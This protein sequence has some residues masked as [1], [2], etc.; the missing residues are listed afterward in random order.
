MQHSQTTSQ[1]GQS[2]M[3]L[4]I[5]L[6]ILLLMLVGMAEITFIFNDYLQMLDGVRYGARDSS[7]N[8]PYT[9][10]FPKNADG[11]L[12][13]GIPSVYDQLTHSDDPKY[14]G[15]TVWDCDN[16]LNFFA[17]AAC[18]TDRN[19][20]Y[21]TLVKDGS[22]R[23][24][25]ANPKNPVP[26]DDIVISLFATQWITDT[27]APV[28]KRYAGNV[29]RG[30]YLVNGQNTY[31]G[32]L[33]DDNPTTNDEDVNESGWSYLGQMCSVI[34][35]AQVASKLINAA[36]STGMVLVEVFRAR[37][38]VLNAPG[39][40]VIPDPLL[41]HAYAIFPLV[42]IEPTKTPTP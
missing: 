14:P 27:T 13:T 25:G 11:T 3:E 2:F 5:F 20:S 9:Q 33:S 18:N 16:T 31:F 30:P 41:I 15:Y 32:F 4:A 36:P 42:S 24:C 40:E 37:H 22:T 17:V 1:R 28:L 23:N 19:L 34:T 12:N 35:K 8:N 39:F 6:P 21:I 29:V 10:D 7:D 26:R 38:K